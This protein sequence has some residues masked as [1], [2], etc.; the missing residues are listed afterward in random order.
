MLN[1]TQEDIIEN[2]TSMFAVGEYEF[3]TI[4]WTESSISYFDSQLHQ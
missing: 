2:A 4:A 3:Y 1:A